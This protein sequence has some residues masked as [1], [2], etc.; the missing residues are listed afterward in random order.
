MTLEAFSDVQSQAGSR[1]DLLIVVVVCPGRHFECVSR[2]EGAKGT[3]VKKG[4]LVAGQAHVS[5]REAV[6]NLGHGRERRIVVSKEGA[7]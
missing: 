7:G 2:G 4:Y 3:T 1:T 6:S 5:S